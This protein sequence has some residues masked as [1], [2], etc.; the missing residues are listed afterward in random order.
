MEKTDKIYDC[1]KDAQVG[2]AGC[3]GLGSNCAVSLAR[4]GV[5]HLV[6]ADFDV[7]SESNLNR[8]YFFQDQ[9]GQLKVEALKENIHR[10]AP[11]VLV[12][13]HA[14][15]LDKNSIKEIFED[16]SIIIE[17][18]DKAEMKHMLIETVL[19]TWPEKYVITGVGLAGWG[20]TNALHVRHSDKLIICGDENYEVSEERPPLS[21]RVNIV[22]HMQANEALNLLLKE[23]C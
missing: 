1:L 8:Q 23:L 21:P 3:G 19:E 15:I 14:L 16:C 17:A 7:V 4:T 10:I 13:N 12:E 6:V 2:I 18:F 11:E 22:A 20:S 9:I 5:G